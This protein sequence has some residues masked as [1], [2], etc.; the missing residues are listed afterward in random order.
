MK[1]WKND[2]NVSEAL[3]TAALG[4]RMKE[5]NPLFAS[6]Y[7][8]EIADW[9]AQ[10]KLLRGVPLSSLVGDEMQ[11]PPE[12]IR[13]F[14]VD[15]SWTAQ[16]I[17]G[18]LSI[19]THCTKA[20]RINNLFA[21]T[22]RVSGKRNIRSPRKNSIHENQMQFYRENRTETEEVILTGFLM[23]SRLVKLWK[24]L[25]SSAVDRNGTKLDILRMD[26]L[27]GETMIC[28]YQGEITGL[29]IRE[30]KEG[31]RFGAHENDR[32][33]RVRDV[34]SGNE[35][36]ILSG[37]TVQITAN[38]QG[39]ADI[40]SLAGALEKILQTEHLTSAELAMELIVAPGLAEFWRED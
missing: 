6:F 13:F 38:E 23:R 19:G 21:E 26:Q 4:N 17:N 27:S 20:E 7:P 10:L 12:S 1:R 40:L 2:F 11:L 28:I 8:E 16:M 15:E 18:A 30:P 32:M 14:Y 35:G 31:L 34:K 24:G 9:I 37:K 25:E 29:R 36:V 5:D 39:R 3:H 22:V 33:I